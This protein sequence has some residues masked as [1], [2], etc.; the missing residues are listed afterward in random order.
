VVPVIDTEPAQAVAGRQAVTEPVAEEV[1]LR[2]GPA[3]GAPRARR[4][5][6]AGLSVGSSPPLGVQPWPV[7]LASMAFVTNPSHAVA[8]SWN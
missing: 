7:L 1:L 3:V 2:L 4:D 8:G 5:P 6:L